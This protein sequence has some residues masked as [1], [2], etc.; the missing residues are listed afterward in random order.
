VVATA[1]VS[2]RG[3]PDPTAWDRGNPHYDPKSTPD[4]PV[5]Y[6]VDITLE[7]I[8]PRPVTLSELRTVAGLQNLPLLRR[9]NRLSIQ[10]VQPSEFEMILSVS[11]SPAPSA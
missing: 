5:W 2:R 10:P 11:K 3:Y 1:R 7:H 6:M 9:G 8:L 4:R